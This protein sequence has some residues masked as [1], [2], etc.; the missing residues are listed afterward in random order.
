MLCLLGLIWQIIQ[1]SLIYFRFDVVSQIG[2]I[3]PENYI[4]KANSLN[5]CVLKQQMVDQDIINQ[6]YNR[7]IHEYFTKY[8]PR[9]MVKHIVGDNMTIGDFFKATIDRNGFFGIY[10]R[11]EKFNVTKE[12]INF[13]TNGKSCFQVLDYRKYKLYQINTPK[14]PETEFLFLS[15]YYKYPYFNDERQRYLTIN[16]DIP[17]AMISSYSYFIDK[18][19]WPYVENCIN[20]ENIGFRDQEHAIQMCIYEEYLTK[21]NRIFKGISILRNETKYYKH[22]VYPFYGSNEN[23]DEIIK[24]CK[25]KY[26]IF[27]DC[28]KETVFTHIDTKYN[29]YEELNA[30]SL[31]FWQ[32]SNFVSS[33]IDSKPSIDFIEYFTFILGALGTWIG[34]SF[35]SCNPVRFIFK[36]EHIENETIDSNNVQDNV[37]NFNRNMSIH[38]NTIQ[39]N[40]RRIQRMELIINRVVQHMNNG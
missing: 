11:Y 1:I 2:I 10:K 30:T 21:Y 20:Y 17:Y 9:R 13:I 19:S 32:G 31:S 5:I 27:P 25:N 4:T 6:T 22:R 36:Q 23:E 15:I 35:I 40:C 18:L 12:T 24:Y 34:F 29:P 39:S 26:K 8:E 7:Y 38:R 16:R 33:K 3:M 14:I 37:R 28:K